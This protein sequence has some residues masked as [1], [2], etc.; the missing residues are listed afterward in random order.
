MTP[1]ERAEILWRVHP[2]T[3]QDL[4][5]TR[6]EFYAQHIRQAENYAFERAAKSVESNLGR[7]NTR[8][9][10]DLRSMKHEVTN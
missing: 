6:Q 1:D 7:T 10:N 4:G 8:L 2:R 9:V 5:I 3:I